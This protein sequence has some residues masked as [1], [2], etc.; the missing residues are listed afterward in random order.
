MTAFEAA[1]RHESF[2]R[3]AA[4]LFLTQGAVSRQVHALEVFVGTDLFRRT[5]G[6]LTLTDAGRRLGQQM[7]PVLDSLETL[8]DTVRRLGGQSAPI[9]IAAYP[10]LASRWLIRRILAY[11]A[12]TQSAPL[13]IETVNANADLDPDRIDLGILQGDPPFPDLRS[14]FL[15]SETLILACAPALLDRITQAGGDILR[16]PYM[17]QVTRPLAMRIWSG[18]WVRPIVDPP[19]GR[20]FERYDMM[21]EAAIDGHGTGVFPE[22][23]VRREL[24]LGQLVLAHPHIAT[25]AAAYYVVTP[26]NREVRPEVDALRRWLIESARSPP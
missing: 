2:S 5:N 23:L 26:E 6:R 1:A 16:A 8:M 15:M 20:Q 3:A 7:A 12:L 21:I 11:E 19:G 24:R 13:R 4:D 22:V 25:P 18:S 10:T 17:R 9:V 14:D